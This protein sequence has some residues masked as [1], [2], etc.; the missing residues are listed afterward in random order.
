M[1]VRLIRFFEKRSLKALGAVNTDIQIDLPYGNVCHEGRSAAGEVDYT[2][3]W[4]GTNQ[5]LPRLAMK[6]KPIK[7]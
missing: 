6:S 1:A 4:N 5:L 2:V 7:C 3:D